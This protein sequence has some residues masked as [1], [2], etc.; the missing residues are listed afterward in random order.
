MKTCNRLSGKTGAEKLH[1]WAF[2]G[3][4]MGRG[5]GVFLQTNQKLQLNFRVI[6][7]SP[8]LPVF[9]EFGPGLPFTDSAGIGYS[10]GSAPSLTFTQ[11]DVNQT[12]H[13]DIKKRT[14]YRIWCY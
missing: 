6:R 2:A 3:H 4:Y 8:F 13:R 9:L 5:N 1:W 14:F 12:L 10:P 11:R 7:I